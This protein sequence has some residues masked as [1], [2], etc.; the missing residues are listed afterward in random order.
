[1][2]ICLDEMNYNQKVVNCNESIVK[3]DPALSEA[4]VHQLCVVLVA[5]LLKLPRPYRGQFECLIMACGHW[6]TYC[7]TAL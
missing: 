7:F 3:V 1:M 5:S 2:L 6:P 4:N